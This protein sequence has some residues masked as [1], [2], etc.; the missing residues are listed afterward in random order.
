MAKKP[1]TAAETSL[2]LEEEL[3]LALD[4]PREIFGYANYGE[5]WPRLNK[6]TGGIHENQLGVM[7]ARPKHGKTMLITEWIPPI[8]EQAILEDKVVKVI[9]LE[10]SRKAYQRRMAANMAG[11]KNPMNIRRGML[12]AKEQ[13]E[14]RKALNYLSS[15]PI[16]YLANEVELDEEEAMRF[17]NS[18]ITYEDVAKFVRG[19]GDTFW[20]V[21]DHAGLLKDMGDG[22]DTTRN[23]YQLANKMATLAHTVATGMVITHLTRLS[24]GGMPSIEAIAGT[25]QWGRNADEIY[26]LWR[27]YLGAG[28][29]SEEDEEATKDGEPAFLQVVSRDEGSGLSVLWWDKHLVSFSELDI[30]EGEHINIPLPKSSKRK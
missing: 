10:M 28:E 6:M 5:K 20:W 12:D 23:M 14:Y 25:D 15:L 19:N 13:V 30:P 7:A 4:N 2:E 21:L 24:V 1:R 9:S 26:L 18:S 17:G 22:Q 11:I 29:L 27:P 3:D 16:E 8:A